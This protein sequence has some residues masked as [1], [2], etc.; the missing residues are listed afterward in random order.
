MR[1]A[2]LPRFVRD[3]RGQDLIEYAVIAAFVALV[4]F[5]GARA[6]SGALGHIYEHTSG[7][8]NSGANFTTDSAASTADCVKRGDSLTP[9]ATP[10]SPAQTDGANKSSCK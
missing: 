6:L 9:D 7:K 1:F 3:N 10:G 2:R 5:L 4:A 8:V